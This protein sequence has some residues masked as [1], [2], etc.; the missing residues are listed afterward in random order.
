[1]SYYLTD[2][3]SEPT[4]VASNLGW[5]EFTDWLEENIPDAVTQEFLDEGETE[6]IVQLTDELESLVEPDDPNVQEVLDS[7]LTFLRSS[8]DKIILTD[9]MIEEE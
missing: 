1:M 5:S 8:P 2:G 6:N 9:G 4:M 3:T 7:V